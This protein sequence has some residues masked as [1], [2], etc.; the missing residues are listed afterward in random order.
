L[1]VVQLN[2]ITTTE[3]GQFIVL[4]HEKDASSWKLTNEKMVKM[5]SNFSSKVCE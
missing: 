5:L 3:A 2:K 1:I 4:K